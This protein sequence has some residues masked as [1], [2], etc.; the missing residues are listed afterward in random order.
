M[1]T[2]CSRQLAPVP[3]TRVEIADRFWQPRRE[4]NRTVTLP[5]EYEINEKNG[6]LDAY[7]WDWWDPAKGNPPWRIWVGDISKWIEAACYSL[8]TRPDAELAALVDHAVES[9][10]KGQK[11]DGY[12]YSNPLPREWRFANLQELHEL[13]DIGHGMEAA[14][15]R[16]QATGQRDMLDAMC[17]YADLLDATFGHGEGQIPGYD[18]H[19][20]VELALVKLY[21]ATGERRYL[22]LAKFFVDERGREPNYFKQEMEKIERDGIFHMGW[23]KNWNYSYCQAHQPLREQQEAFGH[24]VRAL[25]L[26]S[27]A[28]DVAAE[29]GDAELLDTCR[30]LWRSVTHRR[31]YVTGGVGSSP[32]G[33]AFTFDYDLPNETGYAETCANIALVFF[34][35]RMLQLEADGEYA[36]VMERALYNGVMS[37]IGLDGKSFFY[38]NHLTAYPQSTLV[39]HAADHVAVRRQGWFGC[40]C[41]PPNIARLISS[42]GGYIYSTAPDGLFIHLYVGGSVTFQAGDTSVKVTQRTDYPWDEKVVITVQPEIPCEFTLGLRIPGWCRGAR[43]R[44]N[45]KSLSLKDFIDRGYTCII[46]EWRPGDT[47]ELILPMPIER[48]EANPRVRMN[49]GKVALRRGPVVYCLEEIDNGKELAD[50]MLPRDAELTAEYRPRLLGGSVVIRGK[51]LRRSAVGWNDALYRAGRSKVKEVDILAVPYA[52]WANRTPGEMIVWIRER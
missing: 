41:C 33:E 31:M 14:V 25:Y 20:E 44:L 7:V 51:A 30:R 19:P 42:L 32:H 52:R 21:R 24:A 26:Y 34:A 2:I 29:T 47:V 22:D 39:G 35:H 49:C 1:L 11:E 28:A 43:L 37:G 36:D 10:L 38:A 9:M 40:A 12:L 13:Y 18:G 15:A 8:G 45:G 27:G 23:Y 48:I 46:R 16:L 4:T 50:L 17:R 5:L 6:V 3:W